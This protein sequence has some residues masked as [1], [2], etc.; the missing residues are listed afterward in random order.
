[1]VN[2]WNTPKLPFF[3]YRCLRSKISQTKPTNNLLF[4]CNELLY[5]PRKYNSGLTHNA[6][7][8][9]GYVNHV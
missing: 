4:T 9:R 1:M 7:L 5:L 3:P 8:T 6:K 2:E